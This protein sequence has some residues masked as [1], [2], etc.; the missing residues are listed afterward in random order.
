MIDLR[1][2][3]G[4]GPGNGHGECFIWKREND[5]KVVAVDAGGAASVG[6]YAGGKLPEILILSHDDLDHTRG[7]VPLIKAAKKS[8]KEL[9]V[10]VEWALIMNQLADTTEETLF[11]DNVG[12]I[13]FQN[14]ESILYNLVTTNVGT[15]EGELSYAFLQRVEEGIAIL[16][17][18]PRNPDDALPRSQAHLGRYYYG[19]K[20]L[21]EII[22]RVVF[23]STNLLKIFKAAHANKVLIRYFSIDL[24]LSTSTKEW[25]TAGNPGTVTLANATEAP[26]ALAL[27]MPT[28]LAY[29]YALIKLSVQN[30]RA[31]CTL[32]WNDPNMPHG[33][34][35][36]WSDTDG[37]WLNHSSPLGL[38]QVIQ[39]LA[40]SSAPHHGSNQPGHDRAW[41]ELR[42]L[43]SPYVMISA[44]GQWNQGYRT[45][46]VTLGPDRC[47]TR[48]RPHHGIQ[49]VRATIATTGT[50]TLHTTCLGPTHP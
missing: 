28:G 20:S 26:Y 24:A 48:C 15:T 31:L 45:E 47:C 27:T 33:G 21:Q 1:A 37:G 41:N 7:A 42:N 38:N 44:G 30:R 34:T 32:L 19:A 50:P 4:P 29:T 5:D 39:S 46:Y 22:D 25:E 8:L 12:T 16:E 35:L 6:K 2:I 23:S 10:P 17:D 40:I 3:V 36:I 13:S 11:P 18:T 49:E 43:S 9:W 14:A